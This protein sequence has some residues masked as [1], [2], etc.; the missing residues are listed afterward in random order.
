MCIYVDRCIFTHMG[1]KPF[2]ILLTDDERAALEQKRADLGLR[3]QAEVIRYWISTGQDDP[4]SH[5]WS[6]REAT[7]IKADAGKAKPFVANRIEPIKPDAKS[8]ALKAVVD[9][10]PVAP[11]LDVQVGPVKR[12]FGELAKKP[13]GKAP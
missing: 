7:A 13:K 9:K 2:N 5:R 12:G 4:N 10:I 11:A 6:D 3:S 8:K 1:T